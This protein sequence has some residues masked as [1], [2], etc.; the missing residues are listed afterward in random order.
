[1][2]YI[3]W[4]VICV[5][6]LGLSY[7]FYQDG[8]KYEELLKV[9][10]SK[11]MQSDLEL[12]RAN[13]KI[14]HADTMIRELN[15]VIKKEIRDRK[16]IV[17][18]YAD[19]EA[20]YKAEVAK[21]KVVTKIVY[22]DRDVLVELPKGKLYVMQAPGIYK[23]ITSMKWSYKDFRITMN[24][25]ALKSTI[26]YKLHQKF[27]GQFVE[28]RLPTGGF[29]HYFKLNEVDDQGK[30]VNSLDLTKFDVIKAPELPN[31]MHWW[32]PKLDM[33]LG[34]GVNTA[35]EGNWVGEVGMS[36]SAYGKTSNDISW[37]FFRFG[38]GLTSNGFSLSFSPVQYN[39]G[40][41]LPVISNVW[42]L[43]Y[44]GYDFSRQKAH[45]GLGVSVVF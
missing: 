41:L 38:A 20:T 7:Y 6:L 21:K 43:P 2:K 34:G 12:G 28:T 42:I 5:L 40:S 44:A 8:K 31:R 36:V 26:S 1:M 45:F 14:G 22:R 27:K 11:L 3:P 23:E 19:L 32:N 35:L 13:T 24:G 30:I 17:S 37:R 15:T 18:L 33:S 29:N 16:A 9:T 25:D 10:N 4:I 39:I